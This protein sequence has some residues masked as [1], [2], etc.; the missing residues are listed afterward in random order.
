MGNGGLSTY[1]ISVQVINRVWNRIP[2]LD[3]KL[4]VPIVASASLPS[5]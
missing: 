3:Q 2:F 4:N 5:C 1:T